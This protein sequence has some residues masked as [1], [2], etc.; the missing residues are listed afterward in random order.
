[1]KRTEVISF[2]I[3]TC[4]YLRLS[5]GKT[6]SNLVAAAM[7]VTRASL[8]ELRRALSYQNGVATK[9][10]IKRVGRFIGNRRIETTEAIFNLARLPVEGIFRRSGF[11]AACFASRIEETMFSGARRRSLTPDPCFFS[12]LSPPFLLFSGKGICIRE[13]NLSLN[14]LFD[15]PHLLRNPNNKN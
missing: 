11:K 6:L 4:S 2:I 13:R 8:A 10:S 3:L 12:C 7:K 5:Q 1:M 9:H 14:R 15:I